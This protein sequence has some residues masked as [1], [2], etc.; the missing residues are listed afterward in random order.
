[1]LQH[2][3]LALQ[4]GSGELTSLRCGAE[5]RLLLSLREGAE[6]LT[7]LTNLASTGQALCNFLLLGRR[8][9]LAARDERLLL[10]LRKLAE[11]CACGAE[12]L[13]ARHFLLH[14]LLLCRSERLTASQDGLLLSGAKS[15]SRGCQA[16][17][18]GSFL[19]CCGQGLA[20]TGLQSLSLLAKD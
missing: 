18:S 20:I 7:D 5:K 17:L 16:C 10:S 19:L 11:L 1:L 8:E 6:L 9:C 2:G 12:S 3:L 4:I 15:A 14:S 13:R